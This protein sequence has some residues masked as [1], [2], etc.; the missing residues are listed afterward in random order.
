MNLKETMNA[1]FASKAGTKFSGDATEVKLLA[2]LTEAAGEI[3]D[4]IVSGK[5]SAVRYRGR[6]GY[7]WKAAVW[8]AKDRRTLADTDALHDA[9]CDVFGIARGLRTNGRLTKRLTQGGMDWAD[10]TLGKLRVSFDQLYNAFKSLEGT[11][12]VTEK[13]AE[14]L[15]QIVSAKTRRW[16]S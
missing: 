13:Q 16:W 6:D 11:Q 2:N 5:T 15:E 7:S 3:A 14:V 1:E 10:K 12:G 4:A 9:L 8:R